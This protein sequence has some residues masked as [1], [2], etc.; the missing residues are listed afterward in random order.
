M[1]QLK[2]TVVNDGDIKV[3][4][5]KFD[6][7]NLLVYGPD[8]PYFKQKKKNNITNCWPT[9]V[10]LSIIFCF[11]KKKEIK[12]LKRINNQNQEAFSVIVINFSPVFAMQNNVFKK[13]LTL[14]IK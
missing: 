7:V 12:L 10:F 14:R 1:F 13:L 4:A 2:N 9:G 5:N 8:R 6:I 3:I 11:L